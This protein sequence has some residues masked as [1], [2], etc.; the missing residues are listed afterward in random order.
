MHA[1][2]AAALQDAAHHVAPEHQEAW[3]VSQWDAFQVAHTAAQHL[4]LD[5]HSQAAAAGCPDGELQARGACTVEVVLALCYNTLG[6]VQCISCSSQW[7]FFSC[8]PP[9]RC[10]A[11]PLALC[12]C[13]VSC[14]LTAQLCDTV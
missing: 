14:L 8:R 7:Q 13:P 2:L 4:L 9:C 6:M 1:A 5:L 11:V 12:C 10:P 3:A